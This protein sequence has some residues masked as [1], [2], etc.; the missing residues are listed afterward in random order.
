MWMLATC[1]SLWC[2]RPNSAEQ[3]SQRYCFLFGSSPPS[4]R[5]RLGLC[6]CE[7]SNVLWWRRTLPSPEIEC[8]P[9]CSPVLAFDEFRWV[10]ECGSRE[11][12]GIA[13]FWS[14]LYPEPWASSLRWSRE[15][16]RRRI[17]RLNAFPVSSWSIARGHGKNCAV[18]S[19]LYVFKINFLKERCDFP[20]CVII[21]RM[22]TN[23]F[24]FITNKQIYTQAKGRMLGVETIV[25]LG[26]LI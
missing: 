4:G 8:R 11:E 2:L 6:G 20:R 26:W 23:G 3:Y 1:L 24:G 17:K 22:I 16:P 25:F 15:R 21:E 18:F 12:L 7:D 13:A 14:E 9:L 10:E 19:S 5:R